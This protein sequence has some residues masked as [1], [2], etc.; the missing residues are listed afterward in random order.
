M[1]VSYLTDQQVR[2]EFVKMLNLIDE[3][4]SDRE[5]E[6]EFETPEQFW[7]ELGYSNGEIPK[8]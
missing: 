5:G 3:L 1:R 6:P 8:L 4:I 2:S 7:N